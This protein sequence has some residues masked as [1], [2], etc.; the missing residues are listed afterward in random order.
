MRPFRPRLLHGLLEDDTDRRLQFCEI[1]RNQISDE[2]DLLDKIIWSDKTCFKFSGHVNRHNC[3]Y[4]A[5]E[6]PHLT[7]RFQ[8]NQ[9]G[10]TEW[11]ALSSEVVLGP[12]FFDVT[13]DGNNYLNMLRDVVVPQLRTKA[14]FAELYL[15][16][17]EETPH[18]ALLVRNYLGN[19]F[20]LHWI[21]RRG[22]IDWPPRS[23][24]LTPMNIFLWGVVKNKVYDGK[25]QTVDEMKEFITDAFM[26]TDSDREL[27]HTVCQSVS[28]RLDARC[29]VDGGHFEHLRD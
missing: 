18:Y 26:D 15:Q 3:V 6:N 11:G 28:D 27:C 12:V 8:L 5:D 13:L 10:V 20:P 7:I 17:D 24:D 16:Q 21:G 25:P 2:Q 29:D 4:W 1:I 22:S 23:T 14:H 19:L 9:S